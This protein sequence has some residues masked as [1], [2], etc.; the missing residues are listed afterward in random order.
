MSCKINIRELR[1]YL[2]IM[3]KLIRY[4]LVILNRKIREKVY[5]YIGNEYRYISSYMQRFLK[6]RRYEYFYVNIGEN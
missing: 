4:I 5:N 2:L 1:K 3:K 6:I